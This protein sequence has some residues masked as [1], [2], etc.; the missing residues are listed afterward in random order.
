[1][2]V[3]Y[4]MTT[5]LFGVTLSAIGMVITWCVWDMGIACVYVINQDEVLDTHVTKKEKEAI[6]PRKIVKYI[7][8][9]DTKIKIKL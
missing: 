5:D 3:W 8:L 6:L 2:R 4:P 7:I 1:M 9:Q